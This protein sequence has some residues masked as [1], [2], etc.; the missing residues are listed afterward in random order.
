[1]NITKKT[2]RIL[3]VFAI[4]TFAAGCDSL[5]TKPYKFNGLST[6]I[7]NLATLSDA[8]TRSISAENFTGEKGKGAMATVGTGAGPASELG[9]GWKVSPSVAIKPKQTF[10][11]AHISQS[12]A[13]QHIW[14]T[15]LGNWQSTILRIY[16]DDE[17][18]PSVEAPA[19]DFFGCGLGQSA[20][21]ASL[22]VCVNPREGFN[23]YWTM[24]FRKS[25]RITMENSGDSDTAMFYQIDYTLTDVPKDQG[26]FHAQFR[27]IR[28]LP[29][30]EVYTIVDNIKGKGHYVGTVM[31]WI[32][33]APGWWGEGEIKFFMDGDKEFPTICGTGTEDYF[34]GSYGFYK[35]GTDNYMPF[36][37]PYTGMP[38]VIYPKTDQEK[39]D[40]QAKFSLYRWHIT[41]PIRFEKDLRVNIHALGWNGPK[42]LPL[43]DDI[44]S[45]AF[46]YQTEPHTPFPPQP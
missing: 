26:Y 39:K 1:M 3:F 20:P 6:N 45:V 29:Y 14:L 34:C 25:C 31:H 46:W 32:S 10:T 12:G 7:D 18:Q 30:K 4:M 2:L 38:L 5:D 9:Q 11:M 37:T 22:P 16:W 8:R 28:S 44:S 23:C 13:I 27:H 21:I 40:F 15:F 17:Q 43:Q 42:Y 41:D 33:K 24:P 19:G 36:T 35:P